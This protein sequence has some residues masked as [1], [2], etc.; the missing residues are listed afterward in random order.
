M[1]EGTAVRTSAGQV[2]PAPAVRG[3]HRVDEVDDQAAD[4]ALVAR[5]QAGEV[6]ACDA[7]LRR[8]EGRV[9]R[10]LRLFGVPHGDREDVAQEILIRV[11]RH[12]EGFRRG[13]LFQ[14]WL[15]GIAVNAAHDYRR[16]LGQK[17][18]DE[19]EWNDGQKEPTD[20]A[21]GPGEVLERRDDRQRL[22]VALGELSERERAVF[23]LCEL[24]ALDTREVGSALGITRITVRRH[25]GRARRR[26]R[27][28]L[29]EK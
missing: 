3:D 2:V 17:R 27:I 5:A 19:V 11:F 7:L 25:L 15:Y 12:L 14:S 9:L 23:V 24:E 8:H 13:R 18:R 29:S 16:R 20:L 26:L 22:E 10:L 6:R 21:P 28:I 1:S 4:E